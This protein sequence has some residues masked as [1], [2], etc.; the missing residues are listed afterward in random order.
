MFAKM[1]FKKERIFFVI[2]QNTMNKIFQS[3][4]IYPSKTNLNYQN[5]KV[6]YHSHTLI[7]FYKKSPQLLG[8]Y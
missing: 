1:I 5:N 3:Q 8:G 2:M 7:R 6:D 4:T